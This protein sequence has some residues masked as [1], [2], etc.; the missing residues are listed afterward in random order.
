MVSRERVGDCPG[1]GAQISFRAAD[2]VLAVCEYCSTTSVRQGDSLA[3]VGKMADLFDDHS[4]LSLGTIG[5]FEGR[6]F[7][8]VGRLQNRYSQG[9]WNEWRLVFDDGSIA[10]LSEDNASYSLSSEQAPTPA[11][12]FEQLN[13][14]QELTF[15]GTV[16][17]VTYKESATVIAG[18]GELPFVVGSGYKADVIDLRSAD[19]KIA[20]LD[21]SDRATEPEQGDSRTSETPQT[22]A[23]AP[24]LYL[25]QAVQLPDLSLQGLTATT[26]KRVALEAFSCPQCGATV[27]PIFS[28]SKSLTCASCASLL[29]VSQ[30]IGEQIKVHQQS[31]PPKLILPIGSQGKLDSQDW[32]VIGFTSYEGDDGEERFGW[33]EYLLHNSA[34][35]F[36]FLTC[37]TGHWALGQIVQK[38][39]STANDRF[40]RGVVSFDGRRY[41][42]YAQYEAT[43]RYVMGEFFWRVSRSDK[44]LI[45]DYISSPFGLS[46]ERTE[47]EIVWSQAQHLDH[48]ELCA[49]F[50]LDAEEVPEPIGVG[51]LAPLPPS[52]QTRYFKLAAVAAAC[53]I[54]VQLVFS[55]M[56][57]NAELV[58]SQALP[59]GEAPKV[60]Q[61]QL[62]GSRPSNLE[63]SVNSKISNDYFGVQADLSST[64]GALAQGLA[65]EV[66]YYSGR[67]GGESWSEGSQ[68]GRLVFPG[69][70]PGMYTVSISAEPSK[71]GKE[72]P[73]AHY[74]IIQQGQPLWLPFLIGLGAV[75]GL[76]LLG[77]L[78]SPNYLRQRWSNSQYGSL[79]N[80]PR[81]SI[82]DDDDD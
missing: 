68:D 79:P 20:T 29:D 59:Q 4:P 37:D 22:S 9:V 12:D 82:F 41:D 63:V 34:L 11:P 73:M 53:L 1:C 35:G 36:R 71:P 42:Q 16:Y 43:V 38:A 61:I 56:G 39:I 13:I 65:S 33:H 50:K 28:D 19:G 7:E 24:I 55:M 72:I 44:S 66:G 48:A 75:I 78:L 25:G 8:L 6:S 18:A 77:W 76:A 5:V 10:W 46:S 21:Y 74:R 69:L 57:V 32:A 60:H 30:G 14:G 17:R 49:A 47:N 67:S 23:T 80:R 3:R 58:S 52:D 31:P 81:M 27:N 62:G 54:A 51:M 70:Q 15:A 40:S 45:T 26:V 64:D 2:S